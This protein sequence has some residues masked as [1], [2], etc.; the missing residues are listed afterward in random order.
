M[1]GTVTGSEKEPLSGATVLLVPESSR[2]NQFWLF[3]TAT[4]DQNGAFSIKGIVPGSYTVHAFREIEDG[5]WYSPELLK[6]IDG[7]GASVKLTE[8]SA[9]TVQIA[10][11]Q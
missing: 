8:G 10:A 6:S 11:A 7:K 3:R 9:E 5:S 4:T 2:R 1:T